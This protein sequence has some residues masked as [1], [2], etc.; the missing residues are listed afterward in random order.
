MIKQGPQIGLD[1]WID[2][3]DDGISML[4]ERFE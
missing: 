4:L 2:G 1:G 3:W